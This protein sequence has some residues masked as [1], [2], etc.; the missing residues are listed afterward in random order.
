MAALHVPQ[1]RI[2]VIPHGNYV[3]T[4]GDVPSKPLARATLG[5]AESSKVILFFGQIKQVKGLDLLLEAMPAVLGAVPEAVLLIAGRPWKNDFSQYEEAMTRLA[6]GD[7]RL[8]HIRY[9]ADEEVS[10]FYASADVVVL[11]YRRIYQS[12][13]LLL[14]MSYRRAVLVSDIPGM[15][16]V[17]TPGQNGYA[18]LAG[19]PAALAEAMIR[20]LQDDAERER[21]ADRGF[22]YVTSRHD[23]IRIGEQ[24][25]A[26]YCS[27]SAQE[28]HDF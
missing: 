17:V 25:S 28:R 14:A 11:P 24:M 1:P 5:I 4:L 12:G 21:V 6:I 13:V 23:W 18:F 7:R 3:D 22:A 9:I 15:M 19:S 20:V 26:L 2:A 8:L 10:A 27:L 16:D